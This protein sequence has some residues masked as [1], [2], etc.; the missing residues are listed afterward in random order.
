M[1]KENKRQPFAGSTG[2]PP[3]PPVEPPVEPPEPVK[4]VAKK[5]RC[6]RCKGTGTFVS[7]RTGVRAKT[8]SEPLADDSRPCPKC[9][10]RKSVKI[11][12]TEEQARAE[13]AK[14]AEIRK[15]ARA[16]IDAKARTEKAALDNE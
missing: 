13:K 16:A 14:K 1:S 5:I 7:S 2:N 12:I 11:M 15:E 4:M 3:E 6:P 10:G 9:Q 8:A